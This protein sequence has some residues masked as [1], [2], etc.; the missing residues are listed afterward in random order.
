MRRLTLAFGKRVNY[1]IFFFGTK[2]CDD[3]PC[4][5]SAASLMVSLKVGWGWMH[6]A[7]SWAVAP[8]S[9]ATT[10][11]AINSPAPS[12]TRPTPRI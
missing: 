4:S 7:K 1:T 11:S 6:I 3:S 12:P 9:I 10:A 8:I 5:V 2:M